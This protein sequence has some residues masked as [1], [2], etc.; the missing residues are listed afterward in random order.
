MLATL[1][2][3]TFALAPPNS[4]TLTTTSQPT[5]WR[6][7]LGVTA[8]YLGDYAV[9]PGGLVGIDV[10]LNPHPHHGFVL[11]GNLAAYHHPRSHT[12]MLAYPEMGYRYT[13]RVGISAEALAGVGLAYQRLPTP[14]VT[15]TDD[16]FRE[17]PDRGRVLLVPS[18]VIGVGWDLARRTRAPLRLFVRTQVFGRYPI[19]RR[20]VP[21]VA[22]QAG[23][24]VHFG[25]RR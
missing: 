14:V 19:N 4:P 20:L 17:H 18:G 15:K 3:A 1:I 7:H 2:A 16:G 23:L 24:T 12:A 6:P 5:R 21:H 13:A 25:G 11:T 9:H 8:A 22:F 10:W